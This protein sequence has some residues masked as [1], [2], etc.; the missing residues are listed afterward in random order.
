MK[1][2][3]LILVIYFLFI[4][5]IFA[6]SAPESFADLVEDLIPSV[7]SIASKTIVKE[8]YQDQM[9]QFPEGSPFDEFFKEYF[10]RQQ[11][12]TPNERPMIGLGSGFIIDSKGIVVTKSTVGLVPQTTWESRATSGS[13]QANRTQGAISR[14]SPRNSH[15]EILSCWSSS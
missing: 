8:Q 4:P 10:D 3:L 11:R 1:N 2:Y 13:H 7:V 6:K 12:N 14:F 9:P 5:N 15:R